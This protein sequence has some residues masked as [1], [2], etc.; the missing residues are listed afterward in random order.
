LKSLL[1]IFSNV[2]AWIGVVAVIS[3]AP[4]IFSDS[5]IMWQMPISGP[6]ADA[7]GLAHSLFLAYLGAAL[8]MVLGIAFKPRFLWIGAI[9]AGLIHLI[10]YSGLFKQ[11]IMG[12]TSLGY[13]LWAVTPGLLCIILGLVLF[14]II[15][16]QRAET[17]YYNESK[18]IQL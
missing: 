8:V 17:S 2:L 16:R 15:R 3:C 12:W 11:F 18:I 10:A 14:K 9:I 1:L 4:Y 13:L 7:S 6:P 5:R